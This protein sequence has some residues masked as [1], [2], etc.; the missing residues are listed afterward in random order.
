[1]SVSTFFKGPSFVWRVRFRA[2]IV[3]AA[4]ANDNYLVTV[5]FV[6][7]ATALLGG[8]MTGSADDV[9]LV[10]GMKNSSRATFDSRTISI[11]AWVCILSL[12][13]VLPRFAAGFE[14]AF[15]G[16]TPHRR[17]SVMMYESRHAA[18]LATRV[19]SE[20]EC[21]C[22][23]ERVSD[24]MLLVDSYFSSSSLFILLGCILEEHMSERAISFR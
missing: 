15:R 24:R 20:P 5:L 13:P 8:K 14:L 18:R 11:S 22:E 23:R 3:T 6:D 10:R 12:L 17:E 9:V 16:C 4:T 7:T 1:M 21:E 2:G 19:L